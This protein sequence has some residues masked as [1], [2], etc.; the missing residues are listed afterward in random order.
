MA[1]GREVLQGFGQGAERGWRTKFARALAAQQGR[2]D[3]KEKV[4]MA[5]TGLPG[6]AHRILPACR[7]KAKG[8]PGR[9]ETVQK[10]SSPPI[11]RKGAANPVLFA[12]G[13]ATT[14]DDE[15]AFL[16]GGGQGLFCQ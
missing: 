10:S 15:I 4:T 9:M 16:K 7:P 1:A 3:E 13:N 12:D 11:S 8:L 6:S 5:Q 14:G 2:P